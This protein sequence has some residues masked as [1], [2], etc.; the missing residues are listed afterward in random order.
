MPPSPSLAGKEGLAV[1]PGKTGVLNNAFTAATATNEPARH[2][3]AGHRGHDPRA[4]CRSCFVRG[5]ILAARP[6]HAGNVAFALK[7]LTQ[8]PAPPTACP[9]TARRKSAVFG[10]HDL[11]SGF[12][13]HRYPAPAGR[14]DSS[15]ASEDSIVGL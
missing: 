1:E 14:Q 15:R 9:T 6:G 4:D 12:L 13:P 11:S 3:P 8:M 7:E 10:I 5:H 2:K